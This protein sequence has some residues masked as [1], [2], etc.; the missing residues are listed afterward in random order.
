MADPLPRVVKSELVFLISFTC[1]YMVSLGGVSS[2]SVCLG[3]A[4][5][6]YCGTPG[7]FILS[8]FPCAISDNQNRFIIEDTIFCIHVV[9]LNFSASIGVQCRSKCP[10]GY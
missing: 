3:Y 10:L 1:D 9:P 7:P 4:T 2:S 8:F 6:F 5:I